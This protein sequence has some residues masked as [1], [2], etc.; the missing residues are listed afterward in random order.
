MHL[1]ARVVAKMDIYKSLIF[2]IDFIDFFMFI[3]YPL[4]WVLEKFYNSL[5]ILLNNGKNMEDIYYS[6][7]DIKRMLNDSSNSDVEVEEKEMIHSIFNFTDTTVKEI[8]TP[9][10]SIIAFDKDEIL[11]NVWNEIIEHEFS[12]IPIFNTIY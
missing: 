9:R 5:N 3:L 12:R 6:E 11:D 4:L 10:T 2:S 8:M 7:E 1:I